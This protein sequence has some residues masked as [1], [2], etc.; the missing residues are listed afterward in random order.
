MVAELLAHKFEVDALNAC[1]PTKVGERALK[2]Q[3]R[4]CGDLCVLTRQWWHEWKHGSQNFRNELLGAGPVRI[5]PTPMFSDRVL[6]GIR[7]TDTTP[8]YITRF[9]VNREVMPLV[10]ESRI[11]SLSSNDMF[12]NFSMSMS[13]RKKASRFAS[14]SVRADVVDMRV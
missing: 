7:W 4:S 3:Q 14:V 10:S 13:L 2:H 1:A 9:V 6:P 8:R 5:P 11:T 12:R